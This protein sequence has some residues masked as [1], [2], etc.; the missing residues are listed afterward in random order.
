MLHYM[1]Q[2]KKEQSKFKLAERVEVEQAAV[3]VKDIGTIKEKPH[4]QH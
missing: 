1:A 2:W 3:I 4:T